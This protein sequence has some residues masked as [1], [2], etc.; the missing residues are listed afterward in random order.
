ME[1]ERENNGDTLAL[2]ARITCEI[3]G[4]ESSKE[5][6][7][8]GQCEHCIGRYRPLDYAEGRMSRWPEYMGL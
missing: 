2:D 3:C 8:L 5:R 7:H 6:S 4:E 1:T